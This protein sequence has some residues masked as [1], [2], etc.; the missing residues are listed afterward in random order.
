MRRIL[1]C[2]LAAALCVSL[3]A[4]G[5]AAGEAVQ[6]YG[7]TNEV[8]SVIVVENGSVSENTECG[9]AEGWKI[10][11]SSISNARITGADDTANGIFFSTDDDDA[12]F[13]IG[14]EEDIY[15]ID[16]VGAFNTVIEL[17][18]PEEDPGTECGC[19]VG[20]TARGGWLTLDNIAVMT[21]G[22]RA[23]AIYTMRADH[24]T[25][26]VV[27]DSCFEAAGAPGGF[28]PDDR[29]LDGS[30][31]G[32]LFLGEDIWLYNSTF[33]ARDGGALSHDSNTADIRLYAVNTNAETTDGGYVLHA[34][35]RTE[36]YLYGS[37][38]VSPQY[39]M[40]VMGHGTA[41]LDS[42]ENADEEALAWGEAD[43]GMQVTE[44]GRS[45]A[46]GGC[47]AV[48]FLVNGYVMEP[49]VLTVRNAVLSTMAEDIT[50]QAGKEMAFDADSFLLSSDRYGESWFYL[51]NCL[52]SLIV[53]RSHGAVISLEEGAELRAA[54]GVLV[55]TLVACDPDAGDIFHD[56]TDSRVLADVTVNIDVPVQGDI[57]HQDYQR[58]MFIHVN[59]DYEGRVQTGSIRA[60]NDLWSSRNLAAMLET[61]GHTDDFEL[62]VEAVSHIRSCLVREEDAEAYTEENGVS[63]TIDNGA[64]WTVQGESSVLELEI[65]DGTVEADSV[66]VDCAFGENG[67][68]DPSSGTR[69]E[70]LEP[71]VYRNVVLES[72]VLSVTEYEGELYL[73]LE[74][75]LTILGQ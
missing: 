50:S 42:L 69:I 74:D 11:G 64:V 14:G 13:T 4:A 21:S 2:L 57:L 18:G 68:L 37:R 41:V 75:I 39:G 52:G 28:M 26:L 29:L 16:G 71:G 61:A 32:T 3:S 62:T 10:S 22:Y 40:I 46:A 7:S 58:D 6:A 55:Q 8:N 17:E 53:T 67:C 30:A 65:I 44:D 9:S 12:Q 49:G 5:L 66:Y 47:N 27:N 43:P 56:S 23:S 24:G 48:V 34:A 70:S 59:A 31:R 38:L 72:S 19:G 20:I 36:N 33:L 51:A 60:W 54:N 15:E 45:L 63:M 73:P 35:D 1:S 25:N